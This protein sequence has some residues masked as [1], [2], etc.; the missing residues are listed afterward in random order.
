MTVRNLKSLF[1]PRSIAVI[2]ASSRPH[3]VGATVLHNLVVGGFEGPIMPV[4]PKYDTLSGMKVYRSVKDL[5][6]VPDV[7]VI[8]TPPETVPG[9]ISDLGELGTRAAIVLTAGLGAAKDLHGR[10]MK[11]LMLNAAKP[12]LLRILGPNCVGLLVPGLSL[13]AS[14][15]HTGA[16]PGKIAFVSQSGGMVTGILDWAKSRGI[17]FS[18]F[19]SLGDSADVDFGD[20]LDYLAS[21]PDTHAILLYMEAIKDARKF[22]SAA[23][24][25]ARTKPTLV[26]KA[27]RMPEGAKAAAS[28]TG[29]L[30]G[31]D[32]VYDAAIRRAGM[33]RV[34]TT[35]DLFDAAETL[36]RS[37]PIKGD[38]LAIITNGGGPGV[39]ATDALIG[40]QGKLAM[41]SAQAM[42]RLNEILPDTWSHGNPVDII[43][44]APAERYVD[45][46][47]TLLQE[48]E[49]DATLFIHVP[50]AIVPSVDIAAAV[51]PIVK[52]ASRN[53]LA[54]WLGGDSV[55]QA[56]SAFT[57][58]GIP[59]YDTPE[60]AV[61]GFMQIVQYNRNQQLLMEVPAAV[62]H[63]VS[64]DRATA[65]G[66]VKNVLS[67][68]R[69]MLSEPEAK[70]VLAAYGIPVVQTRSVR[71]V[72]EAAQCAIEIGF[73]VALKVLSPDITHKSDVGG[74][75][76]DLED[77]ASLTAAA[78]A[79]NKRLHELR[80]DAQLIGFAV[81]SMVR[82]PQA[83]ELIVGV[84][85][86]PMFGPVILFGQGGI[87][88]EV[89]A[90]HAV[91]LPPL[92]MVL[93]RDL[94][95]RTRVSK[96]LAGY[97]N[98][99]AADIEAVCH[100]L[101]QISQLIID[102]PEIAEL[103][104]NPLLADAEGVIALDA[105]IG[106]KPAEIGGVDRLAIRPYPEALEEWIRWQ[107]SPVLLRPIKPEDGPQ[108][109]EFFN[110]LDP[111]DVRY[112]MFVRMRELTNPQLARMT[113]IDYNREMA[114]IATRKGEDDAPETLGVARVIFDPDNVSAEFAIIV[115]TDLKGKGLG[116]I[117][118]R[119]LVQYCRDRG[120]QEIVGE[121]LSYN[122]ALIGLA[123]GFGFQASR[124]VENDTT[125]L[126]LDLRQG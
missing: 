5:P 123:R 6:A 58:A 75:V 116:R 37:R 61:R 102:I 60:E 38:R 88:V 25:A 24:S 108:H 85:S 22:M 80:P 10:S 68:G 76:L 111:E 100:V 78:N 82:R 30:T 65:R 115:R 66:V 63:D 19:I 49:V 67:S 23:R 93:A 106:V 59:T 26:I 27:G 42:I 56:R 18:R 55:A 120:T 89:T 34:Y 1:E 69:S 54:C 51:A 9:I 74:V 112:R 39:L 109:I 110:V 48:K 13:N 57:D 113:Q 103:D 101:I 96:L 43:G 92:N 119:K 33:L 20:T 79:M 11:E 4:N 84:T 50:T 40:K 72:E 53:I 107:D 64:E 98:L 47:E 16:L 97:R 71:T 125:H 87:A 3:S 121:T 122:K 28:H 29:S 45:T 15:A 8:C 31:S 81:Q 62:S 94:I 95:S 104:I 99:P 35:M 14:F 12:H 105:R 32:D 2:G 70:Q 46:L 52:K 86:D 83:R 124:S 77:A 41:L 44:D 73:P 36:A 114:F 21:D 117:L 91:A 7:A 126:V 17:G 90:D 118:M